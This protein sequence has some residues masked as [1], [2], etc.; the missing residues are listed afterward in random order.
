MSIG[1]TGV[2]RY[3][4]TT[5]C[6]ACT[7]LQALKCTATTR[8]RSCLKAFL[9]LGSQL[10]ANVRHYGSFKRYTMLQQV[11]NQNPL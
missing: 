1:R 3:I 11:A 8:G 4:C 10:G 5:Q 6:L 7:T 2:D 9:L